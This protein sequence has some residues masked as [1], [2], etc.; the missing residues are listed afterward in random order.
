MIYN[1]SLVK[2]Y[3]P[4]TVPLGGTAPRPYTPTV[5]A[6]DYRVGLIKRTFAKKINEDKIIEIKYSD[7]SG[8]NSALYKVITI[9]WKVSGPRTN[10]MKN[11][12]LDKAGVVDQNRFEIDRVKTEESVDL[13]RTLANLVEFWRGH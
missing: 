6:N 4:S 3:G 11:G 10:V 12:I 7:S 9:N 1:D 2:S 13:S 8:V 5:S